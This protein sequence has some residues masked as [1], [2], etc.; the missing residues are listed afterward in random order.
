M[1]FTEQMARFLGD[2]GIGI[3]DPD[4]TTGNIFT[5][6]VPSTPDHVICVIPQGG[7]ENDP[8]FNYS[9]RSI[10]IW[11]R[12]GIDYQEAERKAGDIIQLL[13]GFNSQPLTTGGNVV[14][15]VIAEQDG[16]NNVGQ[17]DDGR[18]EFSQ[19]FRIEIEL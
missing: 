17:D 6:R 2:N 16:P 1:E 12:S 14:F 7:P 18:F 3:F 4:G 19:N 11:V 8:H 15:D 5:N 9:Y 13:R 10:Q